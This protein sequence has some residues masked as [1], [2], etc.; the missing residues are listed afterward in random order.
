M[1][2]VAF[3]AAEFHQPVGALGVLL[4]FGVA[5]SVRSSA[6]PDR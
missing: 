2:A 3:G 6:V 4:A 1:P 5:A